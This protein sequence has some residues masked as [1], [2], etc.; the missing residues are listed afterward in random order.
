MGICH[1]PLIV[2]QNNCYQLRYICVAFLM[3]P[4]AS[5]CVTFLP[6]FSVKISVE[7]G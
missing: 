4:T 6:S 3:M 1:V 5:N 7:R 2:I